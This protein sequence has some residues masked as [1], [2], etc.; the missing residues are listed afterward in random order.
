MSTPD[1]QSFD[2]QVWDENSSLVDVK[3]ALE[4]YFEGSVYFS[5]DEKTILPKGENYTIAEALT[6]LAAN[7]EANETE[8]VMRAVIKGGNSDYRKS[9]GD[10]DGPLPGTIPGPNDPVPGPLPGPGPGPGPGPAPSPGPTPGPGPGPGP[11]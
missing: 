1:D 10:G 5:R 2:F 4:T 11:P 6:I 7:D 3:T 9:G 8:K